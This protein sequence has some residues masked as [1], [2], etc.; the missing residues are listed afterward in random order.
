MRL[1]VMQRRAQP[2]RRAADQPACARLHERRVQ[3]APA[4]LGQRHDA[5]RV[6]PELEP[7]RGKQADDAVQ[8]DAR[9]KATQ[10]ARKNY[11][12]NC[13]NKLDTPW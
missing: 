10:N 5:G 1:Y 2:R 6:I 12:A 9:R 13:N 4:G 3:F 8:G 11:F 7:V